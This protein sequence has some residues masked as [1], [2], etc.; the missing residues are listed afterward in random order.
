M[1]KEEQPLNTIVW[2]DRS[3]LHG[4]DYNPNHVATPEMRLLERSI[5]ESGWT[6]PIVVRPDGEHFEIVDG[7]HRWTVSGRP[8]VKA[9]TGGEVPC[10]IIYPDPAQQRLAT[11]R[12]NRARGK[13]T[14]VRMADIVHD[15]VNGLDVS[16]EDLRERLGMDDEEIERLLARGNMLSRG[17]QEGFNASWK[18]DEHPDK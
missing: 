11:I 6:Q 3:L 14:V 8:A 12:H 13:H 1:S 2:L 7:F 18:P 16:R 4:N 15:L 9:M 5:I 10:V 17:A